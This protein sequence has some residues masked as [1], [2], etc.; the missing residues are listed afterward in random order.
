MS[1]GQSF[2]L[3]HGYKSTTATG[4]QQKILAATTHYSLHSRLVVR[5]S[6]E[7]RLSILVANRLK[8]LVLHVLV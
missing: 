5:I 4:I 2:G 6:V 7:D 8:L 1:Q 3:Q